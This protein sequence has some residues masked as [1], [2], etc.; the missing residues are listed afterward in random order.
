[1]A[2]RVFEEPFIR[3]GERHFVVLRLSPREWRQNRLSH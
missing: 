2:I 3:C 1:M